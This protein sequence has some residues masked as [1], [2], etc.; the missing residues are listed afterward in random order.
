MECCHNC[1][2]PAEVL[3]PD[4]YCEACH[5]SLSFEDCCSGTWSV[6]QLLR[7]GHT[8]EELQP[9]YPKASQWREET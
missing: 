7:N 9:L 5:V 6:A 3:C 4:R 8:R 2:S 1:G